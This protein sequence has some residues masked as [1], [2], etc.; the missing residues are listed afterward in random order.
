MNDF[1]GYRWHGALG[2]IACAAVPGA[3]GASGKVV[4]RASCR[5][6]T[7]RTAASSASGVLPAPQT[8]PAPV[9]R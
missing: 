3:F 1:S 2:A 7:P 6:T 9:I 4:R 5:A 8:A